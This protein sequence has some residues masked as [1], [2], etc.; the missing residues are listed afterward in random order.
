M[1]TTAL[2]VNDVGTVDDDCSADDDRFAVVIEPEIDFVRQVS[3]RFASRGLE[4]EDLAQEVLVKAFRGLDGFDGRYPRAWLR[5]IALNTAISSNRRNRFDEVP[6]GDTEPDALGPPNAASTV[7]QPDVRLMDATLDPVL[8]AALRRLSTDHRRVLELVDLAEY[9]YDEAASE[10]GVPV[11]TV[12]SRVHRA[13]HNLRSALAGTH[14][15]RAASGLSS[16]PM[17]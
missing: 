17:A 15:D 1:T 16:T 4:S 2:S 14:L 6:L 8:E 3:R 7:D 12:M 13:R 5:R 10:L 11:G 9:S